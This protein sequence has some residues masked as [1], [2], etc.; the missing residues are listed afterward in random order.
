M[1][2]NMHPSTLF[3]MPGYLPPLLR[4]ASQT[5]SDLRVLARAQRITARYRRPPPQSVL[6]RCPCPLTFSQVLASVGGARQLHLR[7]DSARMSV[8]VRWLAVL[9]CSDRRL[10]EKRRSPTERINHGAIRAPEISSRSTTELQRRQTLSCSPRILTLSSPIV[11]SQENLI[12]R[13][14][15]R[16]K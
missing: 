6:Q 14:R 16:G 9:A 7:A 3:T 5:R 12:Y 10:Q 8:P 2:K 13:C 11:S 15:R 4:M 1:C